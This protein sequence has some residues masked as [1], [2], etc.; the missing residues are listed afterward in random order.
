MSKVLDNFLK[1]VKIHTTSD[2]VSLTCPSTKI[3]FDLANVLAQQL[4]QMGLSEVNVDEN[5]YVTA[6]IMPNCNDIKTTIGFIAHM[7]TSPA[8]TGKDV[9]PQ[10]I[11]YSGGDIILNSDVILSPDEFP[12]LND[13]IG[14]TIITTDGNTL[15]GADD[16][17]GIAEIMTAAEYIVN[18]PDIK[19]GKICIGFTPDEEIGRGADKFDVKSFNADFAYT[20]DGGKIGELEYENFNAAKAKIYIHGKNVHPGTA[21]N[22]MVNSI[23]IASEL[24][25]MLPEDETPAHTQGYE[26]FYH[27]DNIE[28]NVEQTKLDYIIRDFDMNLFNKR[29]KF[30]TNIVNKL[31]QKY[32]KDTVKIDLQDQYFNMVEKINEKKYIVDLALQAMKEV[33][34]EP[35]IQPIRGGTDGSRLSF[36]GLPCPNIFTG[37]HNFHGK[38]EYIPVYAMEKAVEVIVKIVELIANLTK[39]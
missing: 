34:V 6:S 21:K 35:I 39:N 9:N 2:E 18:N 4:K 22:I 27:L 10:I 12:S 14:K 11:E 36:M 7:D 1:Y 3:Q 20:V 15:L 26:G 38:Y 23:L 17:A 25:N 28:G 5:A 16:K 32:G 37:G 8:V 30:I 24:I 13:Y 19:H 29:K 31:N 33:G